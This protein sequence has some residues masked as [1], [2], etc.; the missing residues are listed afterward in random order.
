MCV[1]CVYGVWYMPFTGAHTVQ[2]QLAP[3]QLMVNPADP[4]LV[5]FLLLF[6]GLHIVQLQLPPSQLMVNPADPASKPPSRWHDSEAW[7]V[8]S[9]LEAASGLKTSMVQVGAGV[10]PHGSDGKI[11]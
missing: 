11:E 7:R 10:V 1:W 3:P 5:Y 6:T 4:S 9:F 8:L 2:L